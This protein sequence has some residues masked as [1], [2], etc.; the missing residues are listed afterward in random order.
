MLSSR[1]PPQS[2]ANALTRA[3]ARVRAH[4]T[5]VID[6]TGSNPT[7]AGLAYPESF[8][9]GLSDPRALAYEPFPLGLPDARAA[10]AADQARRGVTVDPAHVVLTASTSEAYSYLFKLLC[11]PGDAVLG[12]RPSYPLFEHL[13]R[14]EGVRL[15]PYDLQY[16]GRWEVDP[17]RLARPGDR[18]RAVLAVA[19]N[20]PTGSFLSRTDLDVLRAACLASRGALIV[21][22]VFADYPLDAVAPLTDIAAGADEVLTFTLGGLSKTVGLPQV[23][24]GW[25]IV[26]GP[27]AAVRAAIEGLEFIADSFLSVSTPVQV[28]VHRLLEEGGAVREAIRA[29][30]ADNLV[31]ARRL[32]AA[33][34]SCE[35]LRAE[36]GWSAVIRVPATRGE[37]ELTLDLLERAHALVHPGYFFDFPREAFLVVSLLGPSAAFEDGLRRLLE[38]ASA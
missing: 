31:R 14:L 23:K 16:H 28:A 37:E 34:P 21:D 12:P 24:C 4:G 6:L 5:P 35:I 32:V 30:T 22:E 2:G 7:T 8:L 1:L 27:P 19:P 20:N 26:G 18:V 29:R 10:V 38:V 25:I 9:S 13:T 33:F 11:N 17:D 3:V 36:G 15:E